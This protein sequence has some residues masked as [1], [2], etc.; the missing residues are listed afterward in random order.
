MLRKFCVLLL[1]FT[2]FFFCQSAAFAKIEL[3]YSSPPTEIKQDESF[4]MDVTL[5][6]V[7][8]NAEYYL[9]GVFY[10]PE[11]TQYFG[12]TQ[13]NE[14]SWNSDSSA[15]TKFYKV[16]G[17]GTKQVSFKVDPS[18]SYF[19]PNS[20]YLFKVGRYTSAGS[21][22]WSEQ[23]PAIIT[24]KAILTPTPMPT[25]SPLPNSILTATP[26]PTITTI[27]TN[28]IKLSEIMACPN[29]DQGEWV[30]LSNNTGSNINLQNWK[31]KDSTDTHTTEFNTSISAFGYVVVRIS[32]AILNN[33]GDSVRL[34][35][36]QNVLMDQ[37]SYLNCQSGTSVIFINGSWQVTQ[38]ITQGTTNVL[39]SP[40]TP[41][42]SPTTDES[43][44]DKT[45]IEEHSAS[46]SD[47][48]S[49]TTENWLN[50]KYTGEIASLSAT[51]QQ[52]ATAESAPIV[53]ISENTPQ[54]P[55]KK[56]FLSLATSFL[57][58]GCSYVFSAA[59]LGQRWYNLTSYVLTS[60]PP[61]A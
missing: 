6:G 49:T 5:S 31:I 7:D 30:E 60:V 33:S 24:V 43:N 39:L 35:S 12:F 25:A 23:A 29:D 50:E 26:S 27:P 15:Y 59:I 32:S 41:T 47:Q 20:N 19:S 9:R 48:E 53:T 55:F 54:Q 14:S 8:P 22:T 38:Q 44:E 21:L 18:S 11:S 56:P 45:V 3:S 10:K 36:D 17:N 16:T 58:A 1:P 51:V 34:F 28:S 4:S 13:N 61:S 42:P 2:L 46:T 37:M 52:E 40:T 57:L